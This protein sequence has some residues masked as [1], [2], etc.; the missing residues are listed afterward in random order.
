VQKAFYHSVCLVWLSIVCLGLL[1]VERSATAQVS[2]EQEPIEYSTAA[3]N[4][5]VSQ[6]QKKLNQQQHKLSYDNRQGWLPAVLK[7]LE[8]SPD[9]QALV[10]SK[11]S[12]QLRRIDPTRPRAIYFNDHTSIG[13]VQNG[14][15]LE[16]ASTDPQQGVIFYTLKNR[17]GKHPQF[18]R[19][20]GNCLIC[21]ASSRT[22][23]V[24]GLVVRSVFPDRDGRPIIGAGTFTTDHTSPFSER[25]G[26]WYVTGAH[27]Q[28]KHMG[29]VYI[30]ED[31]EP[32]QVKLAALGN[33]NDLQDIVDVS[34]YLKP[35]SDIV[36][37]MVLE[38]QTQMQNVIIRA[39]FEARK[40]IWY[41]G[42]MNRA[43]DRPM[44]Y[45]SDSTIRRITRAVDDL[46]E[47]LLFVNEAKITDGV[48]GSSAYAQ[49]FEARGPFDRSKRSLRAFDLQ[50]RLFK[51]PCSYLIY[52]DSFDGLP[53]A[54]QDE[55]YPRLWAV[56]NNEDQSEKFAHLTAADRQAILEILIATK[57]NLPASWYRQP[58]ANTPE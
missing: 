3:V 32:D 40:A 10:F 9:S 42:V 21:H 39:N 20:N 45:R 38:H 12:F 8:I 11:T 16:M 23:G 13:W 5:P 37:L 57:N 48:K 17:P 6:L 54:V 43:L 26:G 22:K 28:Q 33:V 14:D 36:A 2:F 25:W 47:H 44:E 51:Y 4:D 30:E 55:F 15:V 19:D 41:D 24:P 56:L 53:Q 29:N 35:T 50:R 31:V 58:A 1:F 27:G 34:P 7:A 18:I 46:L 52:S 49:Q